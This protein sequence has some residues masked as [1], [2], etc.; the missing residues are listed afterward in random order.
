MSENPNEP[1]SDNV[2]DDFCKCRLPQLRRKVFERLKAYTPGEQ[3]Q[4]AAKWIKL[5]TN[6]NPYSLPPAVIDELLESVRG[7]LRLYPDPLA[8]Q[9]RKAISE[10]YLSN[11][12]TLRSPDNIL[13]ANGSDETLDIIF[14][15]FI[16]PG[17]IV[18]DF[19]PSYGMYSVLADSYGAKEITLELTPEFKLPDGVFEQKGKLMIICSPNNPDG[20]TVP[21][22]TIKKICNNFP[23]IVLIDD[24]YGDFADESAMTLLPTCPNLVISRTFSKSFSLASARLGFAVAHKC[25]IDLFNTIRL[26]YNVSYFSQMAGIVAMRHWAEIRQNA[27][28]IIAERKRCIAEIQQMGLKV[29]PSQSN[30]YLVEFP[31]SEQ[32]KNIYQELKNRKILIRYWDKPR[33]NQVVRV[34]VGLPEENTAF[35]TQL[36]ALHH[37]KSA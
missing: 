11:F 21:L 4:D 36:N 5:N 22:P 20:N 26:P 9:L 2:V 17:D 6:E 18:I 29:F 24:A 28:K 23:G 34:T 1:C 16:D 27:Q 33:L 12:A 14:K 15:T 25:L 35:I 32:A 30:F 8:T 10:N 7:R 19:A 37:H 13:I 3:P 31:T